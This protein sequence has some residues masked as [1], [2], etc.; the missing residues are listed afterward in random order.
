MAETGGAW[1]R[2]EKNGEECTGV[3]KNH[4]VWKRLR[5]SAVA[6]LTY[7]FGPLSAGTL[8][9]SCT[10]QLIFWFV[11]VGAASIIFV[12]GGGV[13]ESF[14]VVVLRRVLPP[15]SPLLLWPLHVNFLEVALFS[16]HL[17]RAAFSRPYLS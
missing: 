16:S 4:E 15:L 8:S 12:L 1:I 10:L 7:T 3:E 6:F 9:A 14:R 2:V 11:V 5:S 17:V 13:A